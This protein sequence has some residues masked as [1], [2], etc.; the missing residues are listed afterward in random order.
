MHNRPQYPVPPAALVDAQVEAAAVAVKTRSKVAGSC[1]RD[2][3]ARVRA[4]GLVCHEFESPLHEANIRTNINF[5]MARNNVQPAETQL[6][7]ILRE[8]LD[9]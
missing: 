2:P 3:V 4:A 9:K 6:S 1:R 7:P 5:A 8:R